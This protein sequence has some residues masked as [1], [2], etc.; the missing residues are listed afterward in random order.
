MYWFLCHGHQELCEAVSW[1]EGEAPPGSNKWV[2]ETGHDP[3]LQINWNGIFKMNQHDSPCIF[4]DIL[5]IC[6][7]DFRKMFPDVSVLCT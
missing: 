7:K 3:P 6:R 5:W 2:P 4:L 1:R